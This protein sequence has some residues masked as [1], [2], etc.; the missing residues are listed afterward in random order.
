MKRF[1]VPSPIQMVSQST[2]NIS[3]NR[4]ESFCSMT[5]S[6]M[7]PLQENYLVWPHSNYLK[8]K[9]MNE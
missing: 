2:Y 4:K 6:Q 3:L 5:Q 7:P 8:Y 1:L 9:E